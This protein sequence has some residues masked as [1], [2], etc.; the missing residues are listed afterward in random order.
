M[1]SALK[2]L[3]KR[4]ESPERSP[5]ASCS[6]PARAASAR[7]PP[8]A[9]T[10]AAAAARGSKVLVLSTDPAHSLGD[11][12]GVPLGAG[13]DRGRH[14]PVR[15]AGRRAGGLR[16]HLARDPEL[17]AGA[18]SSGPASTRCRPRSSP[19]CPG[20]EEVL[21][22]LEVTRQATTGP[23]DLVVV[24]CAPD[25]GDAAA[26]GPAR[27]AHLV[28]REGLPGPAARAAG[29]PAAAVAGLRAGRAARRRLRRR[30]AAA[31]RAAAGAR[32][33]DGA[34]DVRARSC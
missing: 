22:L 20:A 6:S 23:W 21:A 15:H 10:A 7:R 28:R 1:D 14:R 33:A 19:C 32:G 11:A 26:A 5:C 29:R 30:R 25:G 27:G 4:V 3:K 16:A 13:A 2:E 34:D 31:P 18:S 12:L 24:D 8:S 9:A 17:P